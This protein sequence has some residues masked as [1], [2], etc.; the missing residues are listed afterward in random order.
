MNRRKFLTLLGGASMVTAAAGVP[1]QAASGVFPGYKDSFG[2]LH[3]TTRCI[4]CRK[5]E[6]GCNTVNNLPAP[7]KPF[8]DLSVLDTRR[9]TSINSWTVVN[10]FEIPGREAPV[11]AKIQCNH[12]AEP[13]CASAC[14]VKAFVKNPDG[15]VT[16]KQDLCVGCRYCMIA[17]PFNIP[18]YQYHEAWNPLVRK[19]TLC[20]DRLQEGKLPGCVEACPKGALTFG[21]RSDLVRIAWE[22]ISAS[23][24]AYVPQVYGQHEVGGTAW[25]YISGVPFSELSMSK[26]SN[27][28]AGERTAGALGSVAM[29]VGIWPVLLGGAY[30]I[31]KRNQQ[32]AATEQARAVELAQAKTQAEAE[33]KLK[34]ALEKAE[35]EK[36]KAIAAEVKKAVTAAE[37]EFEARQAAQNAPESAEPEKTTGE[38]A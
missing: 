3:D 11:F 13:A 10:K 18:A 2:V 15:S 29:V 17:C 37:Q 24:D 12:C 26:L 22:R 7:E 20:H 31:S 16:Y 19:C 1:A 36:E 33:K 6:L 25:I 8:T 23:P 34:T 38:D 30:F 35:K 14:F 5:C 27:K 32:T 9:R 4:G 21:K 28:P